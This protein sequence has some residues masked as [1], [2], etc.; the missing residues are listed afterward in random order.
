MQGEVGGRSSWE[1]V[2]EPHAAREE[3]DHRLHRGEAWRLAVRAGA[4]VPRIGGARKAG[5]GLPGGAAAV[6][7]YNPRALFK[8]DS[9]AADNLVEIDNVEFRY[10]VRPVLKGIDMRF[11]RGKVVSI[12]G[13]SGCGKTTTLR[14]IGGQLKPSSG[15][16]RV[17]GEIAVNDSR[18]IRAASGLRSSHHKERSTMKSWGSTIMPTTQRVARSQIRAVR[19]GPY[20]RRSDRKPRLP[21]D[22]GSRG[23]TRF[24]LRE[25]PRSSPP[26]PYTSSRVQAVVL[27]SGRRSNSEVWT[28]RTRGD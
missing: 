15:Q 8:V 10:D 25:E 24:P 23:G 1:P 17:A 13:L 27:M 22:Q 26:G 2:S 16:V 9:V 7:W 5:F 19:T 12:M 4:T 11:P 18:V 28:K 14:L 21:K 3:G 20:V 6:I